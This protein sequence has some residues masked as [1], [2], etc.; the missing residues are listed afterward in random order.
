MIAGIP[1]TDQTFL[2]VS[3]RLI[4]QSDALT[5]HNIKE[6]SAI[7]ESQYPMNSACLTSSNNTSRL[8]GLVWLIL[9]ATFMA[10]LGTSAK[11]QTSLQIPTSFNA[12]VPVVVVDTQWDFSKAH[13]GDTRIL[14]IRLNIADGYHTNPSEAQV[15]PLGDF[16][17]YASELTVVDAP[18]DVVGLEQPVWPKPQPYAP[19]Y[20]DGFADGQL[21]VYEGTVTLYLKVNVLP[22]ADPGSYPIQFNLHYQACTNTFC[23]APT[24][25]PFTATLEIVAADQP[26]GEA[27][28]P[29]LFAAYEEQADSTL[30]DFFGL[31][32]SIQGQGA[33]GALL[34]LIVAGFGGFLL[35]FTPC[36][37]PVIPIKILGLSQ[38][39]G[40]R[41]RALLL[42]GVLSLGVIAFWLV[43]GVLIA[44]AQIFSAT[45]EL[46]GQPLFTISVGVFIAVMAIGMAGFFAIRLPQA[47]YM[48]NPNNQS[49]GGSFV[50]GI[51]TAV[52]SLPCTAPFMGAALG[53]STQQSLALSL[54]TFLAIGVGMAMPYFVL[55][56]NPKWVDWMPRTGP[57]SELL[58]QVMGLL[59]L[60]AALYFIG[61]GVSSLLQSPPDPPTKLYW[62]P[63]M[64]V[65][66]AAALWLVIK[67][68]QITGSPVRRGVFGGLAV[69][70]IASSV[71][72]GMTLTSKGPIDWVYYTPDRFQQALD[73]GNVIVL[74]FTAE[75][76]LNCKTLEHTQLNQQQVVD[77]V[78]GPGVVPMKVDITGHNPEGR[79]KLEAAGRLTIPLL[80]VY[81]PDGNEV[82]K[83]DAYLAGN[84]VDAIDQA[85]GR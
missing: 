11:A 61:T 15:R 49:V 42:G 13:P 75:W 68:V 7:Q 39:A 65:V 83:S 64:A 22:N 58:K 81:A 21:M 34:I 18:L 10:A 20:A 8:I 45:N 55:S 41:Q 62:L 48:I 36:V 43:I 4:P 73:E 69:L 77:L 54:L 63:V 82:F 37:L 79:A 53:W 2:S 50:F 46:F 72:G 70:M 33:L 51:M 60:A 44:G 40:S 76:C 31:T 26:V 52:L 27:T 80:V 38:H 14:A 85:K 25:V 29:E 59:M 67:T 5:S 16:K 28:D 78:S 66:I 84:V 19:K 12:A 71:Y 56:A 24:D 23:A 9:V 17:P 32:F 30:F 35:N 57:A 47:V 3:W 6:I 1:G 74:D